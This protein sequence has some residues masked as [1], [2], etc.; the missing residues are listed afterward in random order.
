MKKS[1]LL[2]LV[3]FAGSWACTV[4]SPQYHLGVKAEMAN[5]WE[6]AVGYYEKALLE[7]PTS[8][9]YR[10]ARE[11]A[12][13]GAS[14]SF[15]H[16]AR[17][18][19]AQGKKEEAKAAYAKA[20]AYN[21][22]DV[23]IIHESQKALA[24]GPKEAEK[25]PAKIEFPIKLKAKDEALQLRFPS[26]T[27][28]RSIFTA[29]GRAGGITIIFDESFRDVPFSTDATNLTFEQAL[30]GICVATRNFYRIIDERT[31]IVV[32]DQPLKR[33]QYE[34]AC[35]RTFYI[36]NVVAQELMASLSQALRSQVKQPTILFDKGLNSLTV[37]ATPQEME[38]AERLIKAW[39]KPKGEVLIFVEIMEVSRIRLRQLGISF[40]QNV[41]GL[42]YGETSGTD[43]TAGWFP[44][45]GVNLG[46]I[47][48]YSI[49]LP[50][51]FLQFLESDSDTKVIAKP[52][53]RGVADE[54]IRELVGQKI[55]IPRTTFTPFAAGGISQQPIVN[56][57]QQ[58]VGIEVKI[59]PKIHFEREVTLSA[60]IK[61]TAIGG[62]GYADIPIINTRELK[63]VMRL[64]EG[65]TQ[66][67]AGLLRDEERKSIKGIPFLKNIP[68]LGQL[69]FGGEDRTVEQS[70]VI[71]ALTPY[72]I[73]S[74]PIGPE[75][76]KPIWVD[77]DSA[78][79]QRTALDEDLLGREI[80]L[81]DPRRMPGRKPED[82]SANILTLS[83]GNF[84]LPAGREVRLAINVG[85]SAEVG[86]MTVALNFNPR[87]LNLKDVAEGSLP[88]SMGS[89]VPFLKNIDN[90][91][92][93]CII[94]F[95]SPQIGKGARGGQL[96]ILL[97]EAKSPGEAVVA[98]TSCQA[99]GASG[100][101]LSFDFGG[102]QSRIIVRE[103]K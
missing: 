6:Q 99:G 62:T 76:E 84:E 96:A 66:I 95:S 43:Q 2:A 97:F 23:M 75:D 37:R 33:I 59:T 20:M 47:E 55:P 80:D 58:D 53:L 21:P 4:L 1:A 98:V 92:G 7:D 86:T 72:I 40:D 94:G 54:E 71:L 3:L 49:S 45:S 60:D 91:G 64:R 57:E 29:L 32:P 41:I 85:G 17:S 90:S 73:R 35:I 42:R 28:L 50:V 52:M 8:S 25:K 77:V 14:L 39:D 65:E 46:N 61:V 93:T 68:G 16:E 89:D 34:I 83:P 22:R 9:F 63:G 18:L 13:F 12:R 69:L 10:A 27:S 78:T 81:E 31:V 101:T 103:S 30:K 51:G 44:L 74:I 88:R 5:Q 67:I 19:V 36:S 100:Q 24:E 82:L 70:D 79:D 87:V 56:Y 102:A 15:L 26:E 48:N 38:L 11:R